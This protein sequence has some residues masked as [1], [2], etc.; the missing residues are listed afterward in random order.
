MPCRHDRLDLDGLPPGVRLEDG[1][2]AVG[3]SVRA[4]H[5][6][7]PLEGGCEKER[8]INRLFKRD[9]GNVVDM[10]LG[11]KLNRCILPREV[12]GTPNLESTS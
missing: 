6:R 11:T 8:R 2:L 10:I 1:P 7:G 3:G 12:G 4:L 5:F 9:R